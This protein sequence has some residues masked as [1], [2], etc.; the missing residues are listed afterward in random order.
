MQ[1]AM[2]MSSTRVAVVG[3]G[4]SGLSAAVCLVKLGYKLVTVLEQHETVGGMCASAV[5]DDRVYD[6]GG[7]VLARESCPTIM[8][9]VRELDLQ[10]DMEDMSH[11]RLAKI[12]LT[13]GRYEDFNMAAD[14][15]AL[16]A[17]TSELQAEASRTGKLGIHALSALAHEPAPVFLRKKG[18]DLPEALASAYTGSGYGFVEDI[19]YAYV[20]EFLRSSMLGKI[21][22]VKD[23]YG[24][25]WSKVAQTLPD[26]RC[27]VKVQS[28]D[29]SNKDV[30]RISVT[31]DS[32]ET[33]LEFDKVISSG[34]VPFP[35]GN[36]TYRSSSSADV[37][38]D[39]PMPPAGVLDYTKE[40]QQLFSKVQTIEYYTSVVTISGLDLPVGFYFPESARNAST[41]GHIVAFQRFFAD[42]DVYLI[43]SYGNAQCDQQLVTDLLHEDIQRMGGRVESMIMQ[44]KWAYCPHVNS[45]DMA[46]GFYD[47][48][49]DLQGR[50]STYYVGGLL[51]FELTESNASFAQSLVHRCFGP[52]GEHSD[53]ESSPSSQHRSR[54]QPLMPAQSDL[55]ENL[56]STK[57]AIK[58]LTEFPGVSFPNLRS[59]NAYLSF[60]G[61]HKLHRD[62]IACR[63]LNDQGHESATLTFGELD[64][65]ASVIAQ[66]L[67]QGKNALKPGDRVLMVYQPGLEFVEAFFGCLRAR[68]LPV[69]VIP[70]DPLKPYDQ[71]LVKVAS[72]TKA[73]SSKAIL[74][75]SSYHNVVRAASLR[76][77]V[78]GQKAPPRTKIGGPAGPAPQWPN[79]PWLHTDS[80]TRGGMI[81]EG[82]LSWAGSKTKSS[83]FKSEESVMENNQTSGNDSVDIKMK[84]I[85]D[86]KSFKLPTITEDS[87]I[88]DHPFED[89]ATSID[90]WVRESCA[91][92]PNPSDLCFLQ[93]TSGSTGDPKGVMITH[94]GLLHN[95]LCMKRIYR[96]TSRT[97]AISWLP[98]YH[99]MGLIGAILTP[100]ISGGSMVLFSPSTFIRKPLMW[101]EVIDRYKGTHTAA[102]NFAFELLIKRYETSMRSKPASPGGKNSHTSYDLSSLHFLMCAAEPIRAGTMRR[103]LQLFYS[104]GMRESI[105]AMAYGLAE[106][107]VFVSAS[108]GESKPLLT[109]WEGRVCV[110]YAR[111][112]DP[113]QDVRIVSVDS[114]EEQPEG[115]E[116]EIWVC[117]PSN[118]VGYW[119]LKDLSERTFGNR[120]SKSSDG[121]R[122]LRTGDLGRVIKGHI[123]VTGRIKDLIIIQGRNIYPS[124]IEKTVETSSD[125]VRPGCSATF[126][127]PLQILKSKGVV[128]NLNSSSEQDDNLLDVCVV[129]VAEVRDEKN[130]DHIELVSC[131]K[132]AVANEHGINVAYVD[133][134]RPRSIP[135]TTSGKI[136]RLECLKRF[137]DGTL[138]S[139]KV[140]DAH[141]GSKIRS[142][143]KLKNDIIS[144]KKSR[145]SSHNSSTSNSKGVVK[146]LR[147]AAPL[148]SKDEIEMFLIETLAERTGLQRT[149][150]SVSEKFSNY[151]DSVVM[152]WVS[153]KLSEF[154][155]VHV[156]PMQLYSS[157]SINEIA[158]WSYNLIVTKAKTVTGE[159][160]GP[161]TS[162]MSTRPY[163]RQDS[164]G[165]MKSRKALVEFLVGLVADKI[166]VYT[167]KI[168]VTARLSDYNLTSLDTV[169]MAQQISDYLGVHIPPLQLYT[170]SCLD[171]LADN[172]VAHLHSR[173]PNSTPNAQHSSHYVS[174]SKYLPHNSFS[175]QETVSENFEIELISDKELSSA[176]EPSKL[177]HVLITGLQVLGMLFIAALLLIPAAIIYGDLVSIVSTHEVL[178]GTFLAIALVP[179]AWMLYIALVGLTICAIGCTILKPNYALQSAI[180]LWSVRYVRWWT[181]YRLQD[182]A[183]KSLAVHLRGTILLVWWYRLMGAQIGDNVH[184]D[185]TEISDPSLLYIG[186]GTILEEDATLQSHDVRAGAVRFDAIRIGSRCVVGSFSVVQRGTTMEAGSRIET[187]CKTHAGQLLWPQREFR[188]E[189]V[190]SMKGATWTLVLRQLCGVY[191]QGLV[192]TVSALLAYAAFR[193]FGPTFV[194]T[195]AESSKIQDLEAE[196]YLLFPLALTFPWALIIVA[197]MTLF[198][199]HDP[200]LLFEIMMGMGKQLPALL[201]SLSLSFVVYGIILG[202]L[203]SAL[204]W[205][206]MGNPRS[207]QGSSNDHRLPIK[208]IR[209]T[210][211]AVHG[212]LRSA[213][214]KFFVLLSGTEAL[215]MYLRSLGATIDRAVSIRR[216]NALVDPDFLSLEDN[217]HLGDFSK[218]VTTRI[219]QSKRA[220]EMSST[221]LRVGKGCVVG[222]QSV[223]LPGVTMHD[224]SILGA[225]SVAPDTMFL[226]GGGVYV[227]GRDGNAPVMISRQPTSVDLRIEDMDDTYKQVVAKLATDISRST[228]ASSTTNGKRVRYFHQTGV[229]GRG[230]LR[231]LDDLPGLGPHE[232][233]SPGQCYPVIIRHSNA[234]SSTDDRCPDAK[235]A[236]LRI[237]SPKCP[238]DVDLSM[239][240]LV[241][242][243]GEC[244]HARNMLEL[245]TWEAK[246]RKGQED[247]V[248]KNPRIGQS[249]WGQIRTAE[250]YAELHYYSVLAR[251][252]RSRINSLEL[253][254]NSGSTTEDDCFVKFR[255]R[256]N[257][258][259]FNASHGSVTASGPLPPPRGYLSSSP[260]DARSTDYLREEF[261]KRLQ[262]EEG[263]KY[264]LQLQRH[265]IPESK[266]EVNDLLDP[267]AAWDEKKC[268]FI[269]IAELTLDTV[270]PEEVA[271]KMTFNS[272]NGAP[273]VALVAAKS[274][275]DSASIDHCRSVVYDIASTIRRGLPLPGPWRDLVRVDN[276]DLDTKMPSENQTGPA[277][278]CPVMSPFFKEQNQT[279][280][281]NIPSSAIRLVEMTVMKGV[282]PLLQAAIPVV[283]LALSV[284]P[285]ILATAF[286]AS[287]AG[288][289]RWTTMFPF[290]LPVAYVTV[291]FVFAMLSVCCR[292]LLLGRNQEGATTELWSWHT[293]SFTIWEGTMEVLRGTFVELARGTLLYDE[294][295]KLLGASIGDGV[296]ID[297]LNVLNPD[298]LRIGS[299]SAVGRNAHFFGH[300]YE[301]R[302][303]FYKSNVVGEF[304]TVGTE[305]LMLPG[306]Q[307]QDGSELGALELG[308]KDEVIASY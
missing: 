237:L 214:L 73:S 89:P 307:M 71:A 211:L 303:V 216:V 240:D 106:N 47:K 56:A 286:I 115:V 283:L 123:F 75:T 243:T 142:R 100:L 179:A 300:L 183:S 19:P 23:G 62:R 208:R 137:S 118:G 223:V 58:E 34:S 297:S 103:F 108:Y 220:M 139:I 90:E 166:G 14:Y 206:L 245:M 15:V 38:E 273:S 184:I 110:G 69:P 29:R 280:G 109:D 42:T 274:A 200:A 84:E 135:K 193:S 250:S 147:E 195:A 210:T 226:Q 78:F 306:S 146:S 275:T 231:V 131:I 26:V 266:E 129:V 96:S 11:H 247:Y 5:I 151:A 113:D 191:L 178:L 163:E 305:A 9:I 72:I 278:G 94:G 63:S 248:D 132:S 85:N 299:G 121:R 127:A 136:R 37:G 227:G 229:A 39:R 169:S 160:S 21:W 186:N 272:R 80:W 153:S 27:N 215:C 36:R 60:Y 171:E 173:G 156:P 16:M 44:R 238:D 165:R 269:D 258:P 74:S 204:K 277:R 168:S 209:S 296:Y 246:T 17:I 22:R 25:L 196:T 292:W 267:T 87:S 1:A 150:I 116:G 298:Q 199:R 66:R 282:R 107:C 144:R 154:L 271:E 189:P 43:W 302:K 105:L 241:M 257:D 77:A 141:S 295:L 276:F 59:I 308:M 285:I 13:T 54:I 119:G 12:D 112:G 291:G 98:Q 228:I 174:R 53:Q 86:Q 124:D 224:D 281:T 263:A 57:Y 52:A 70:P 128:Q 259:K 304:C 102:P 213:H 167:T 182:F 164:H 68:V 83:R 126:S 158:D 262:N 51:A 207:R 104:S 8:S 197:P 225:M 152:T 175:S 2:D 67:V 188:P 18:Y 130:V 212:L 261:K 114:F 181:L 138:L 270:I 253:P 46:D 101:L 201:L 32:Q 157:S 221:A 81:K 176:I 217:C 61:S 288:K 24:G 125:D 256:P 255:L 31:Q 10:V 251:V 172:C 64:S 294:F 7:Q 148:I 111:P 88:S 65:H 202:V 41:M 190:D 28:I 99:D 230:T 49:Q 35:N 133:L 198:S 268:P 290:M 79:L 239:L 93:F 264:I 134:I 97:V 122:F 30:V 50:N 203:T 293:L 20:H 234:L 143:R 233:F 235:G 284:Y 244:L 265:R 187:L 194:S 162:G 140:P 260:D 279:Q 117:S 55:Y 149:E 155:H 92:A 218:L 242:K 6:L 33:V 95:V 170:A 192:S 205:F 76:N 180:P 4:P 289:E 40:E 301:R 249:L 177:R 145:P 161:R 287:T 236:A 45:K 254:S 120:L 185:T 222:A 82:L 3:G 252:F 48:L 232:L 91:A 159:T 219:T